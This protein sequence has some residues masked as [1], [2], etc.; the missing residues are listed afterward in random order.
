ML[1][2]FNPELCM[3]VGLD[4]F[5]R[6]NGRWISLALFLVMLLME[7]AASLGWVSRPVLSLHCI[8]L[9]Q[10]SYLTIVCKASKAYVVCF[11]SILS[12]LNPLW[13]RKEYSSLR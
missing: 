7:L 5:E 13:R 11:C 4:P 3:I 9:V 8:G 6:S 10:V 2:T 1:E 12:L